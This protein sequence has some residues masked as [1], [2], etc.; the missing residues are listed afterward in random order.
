MAFIDKDN[1]S[2]LS[3][4]ESGMLEYLTMILYYSASEQC[5][6]IS[7]LKGQDLEEAEEKNW[8]VF[9][10][11]LS[12]SFSKALDTFFEN[13]QQEDMLALVEDSLQPD[14]DQVISTV[15]REIILVACKSIIDIIH[16]NNN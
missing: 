2:L 11:I 12:G 15:G 13:Y 7:T 16:Q 5:G 4:E 10:S 3:S 1:Q 8:G 9:N 6:K 14:E